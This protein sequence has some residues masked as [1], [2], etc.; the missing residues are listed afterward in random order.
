[1]LHVCCYYDCVICLYTIG[2]IIAAHWAV[3]VVA[4]ALFLAT[5]GRDRLINTFFG[6]TVQLI[7]TMN[8]H[9]RCN[10][11]LAERCKLHVYIV[12]SS[13]AR[14]DGRKGTVGS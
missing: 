5:E 7:S 4:K 3:R 12:G 1:M 10:P 14:Y 2:I 11:W 6:E 8:T 9:V 13:L